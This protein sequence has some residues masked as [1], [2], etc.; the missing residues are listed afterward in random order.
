[1]IDYND[2]IVKIMEKQKMLF[3]KINR[4]MIIVFDN[5]DKYIFF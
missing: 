1:M 4:E 3:R 2:I 5:V